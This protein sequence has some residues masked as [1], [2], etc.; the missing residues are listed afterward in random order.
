ML[1]C[2]RLWWLLLLLL[3]LCTGHLELLCLHQ[4]A[5]DLQSQF[6]HFS[7]VWKHV[8]GSPTGLRGSRNSSMLKW[9]LALLLGRNGQR[10]RHFIYHVNLVMVV[11]CINDC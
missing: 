10:S 11:K 3:L 7:F 8:T 9:S 5:V 4:T 6:P 1:V 2:G